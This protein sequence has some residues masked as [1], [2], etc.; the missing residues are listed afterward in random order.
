[1]KRIKLYWWRGDGAD[2]P[3]KRNFGDYLSPLIVEMLSGK[4]IIHSHPKHADMIAIGTILPVEKKSKG[5]LFKRKLHIWGSGTDRQ[6]RV[7]SGRHY[8]HAVRGVRSRSQIEGGKQHIALGDPGLLSD[9]LLPKNTSSKKYK[10]GIIPHYVDKS[11]PRLSSLLNIENTKIINVYDPVDQ[12]LR[13]IQEC[14]SILSSSMHGL[15]V[16]DS[17]GI[18]NRRL[19]LS[20]GIISDYKFD[21]YYSA[22]NIP[23]PEPIT[24]EII[25]KN[26]FDLYSISDD[27]RRPGLESIK[28]AL[29]NSFPKSL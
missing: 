5:L 29:E 6:N 20:R 15:I 3:S 14:D 28:S 23:E 8:Y 16:A 19:L 2:D 4:E 1:M 27:Y 7:F 25:T 13:Q 21:D 18:P 10:L 26:K 12:V 22:F 9:R 24:P 11:D 17:F